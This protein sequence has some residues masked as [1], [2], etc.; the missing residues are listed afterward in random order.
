VEEVV[1]MRLVAIQGG[2]AAVG[3]GWAVFGSSEEEATLRFEEAERKHQEISARPV[4]EG[5]RGEDVEARS[6]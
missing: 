6:A 2:W 5:Q 1:A 4:E 3:D